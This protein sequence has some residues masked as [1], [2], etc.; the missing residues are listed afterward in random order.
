MEGENKL[1][2]LENERISVLLV[3]TKGENCDASSSNSLNDCKTRRRVKR[4]RKSNRFSV[5][6]ETDDENNIDSKYETIND[7]GKKKVAQNRSRRK[8]P[9]PNKRKIVPN[10]ESDS[11]SNCLEI[12]KRME[13]SMQ[14]HNKKVEEKLD[15][16]VDSVQNI[17][18]SMS[19]TNV[20][21]KEFLKGFS[22]AYDR[23]SNNDNNSKIAGNRDSNEYD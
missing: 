20:G 2:S 6:D 15:L 11:N 9:P 19:E 8:L 10:L 17:E 13:K 12:L 18:T 1:G 23:L 14:L 7:V 22:R 4:K 3:D 5:H 21:F 16:L